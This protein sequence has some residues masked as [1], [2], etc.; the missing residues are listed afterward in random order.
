QEHAEEEDEVIQKAVVRRR[1]DA[2][3]KHRQENRRVEPRTARS[4]NNPRR[5][6]LD[7]QCEQRDAGL[8]DVRQLLLISSKPCRQRIVLVVMIHSGERPP[9]LI[10]AQQLHK[11]RL[12]VNREPFP[13]Q[14]PYCR[15]RWRSLTSK[16][17]S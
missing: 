5:T 17:R 15:A 3:L 13:P 14:Q 10:A 8:N 9:L 1:D 12:E 4:K 11:S 2:N 16:A 6:Q 7:D